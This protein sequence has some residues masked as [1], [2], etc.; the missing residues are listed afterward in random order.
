[1]RVLSSHCDKN[2]KLLTRTEGKNI[3]GVAK[4]SWGEA[5]GAQEF[6]AVECFTKE[7]I[8]RMCQPASTEPLYPLSSLLPCA[9]LTHTTKM[10]GAV[11]QD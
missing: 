4:E 5:S 6:L 2:T 3:G 7:I 10:N 1:M 11:Q 9:G 8:L